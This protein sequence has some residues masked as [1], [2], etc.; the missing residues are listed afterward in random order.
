MGNQ[1]HGKLKGVIAPLTPMG[2]PDEAE[3]AWL[4]PQQLAST[5]M[6]SPCN[7]F[8]S[9]AASLNVS[10]LRCTSLNENFQALPASRELFFSCIG[11][12]PE[13]ATVFP[14]PSCENMEDFLGRF[15][16]GIIPASVL[17]FVLTD[18]LQG[19]VVL[20]RTIRQRTTLAC[21]AGKYRRTQEGVA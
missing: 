17:P 3:P 1:I 13:W 7:R 21:A 15:T 20:S 9:S 18:E 8:A 2:W 19:S 11:L 16:T 6:V 4:S 10:A 12:F 5:G 14:H